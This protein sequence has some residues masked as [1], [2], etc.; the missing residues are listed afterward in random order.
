MPNLGLP[1]NNTT[2]STSTLYKALGGPGQLGHIYELMFSY[3]LGTL[4]GQN[5]ALWKE[6]K[7]ITL[8]EMRK[9]CDN[10]LL[11]TIK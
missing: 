8:W 11:N 6:N 7:E 4:P 3:L 2:W 1:D 9:I 10:I 5:L